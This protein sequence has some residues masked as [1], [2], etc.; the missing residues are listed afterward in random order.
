VEHDDFSGAA[1]GG[2]GGLVRWFREHGRFRSWY[3]LAASA[4]GSVVTAVGVG[5]LSY[6]LML[7][8]FKD[9]PQTVSAAC[10]FVFGVSS[11]ILLQFAVTLVTELAV[12]FRSQ[13]ADKIIP[14]PD[15]TPPDGPAPAPGPDLPV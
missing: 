12:R 11:G 15:G 7:W 10:S 9:V 4:I 14:K 1:W 6:V 3:D 13:V 2:L 8:Q 5:H